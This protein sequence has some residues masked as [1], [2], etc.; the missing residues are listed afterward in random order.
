MIQI[1]ARSHQI[2][3]H[4]VNTLIHRHTFMIIIITVIVMSA[5]TITK[6]QMYTTQITPITA[7]TL[8]LRI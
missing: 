8:M 4:Q 6:T 2:V 1:S 3:I 5:H 7:I